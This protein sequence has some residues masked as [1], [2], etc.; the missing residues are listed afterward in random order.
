[1]AIAAVGA[2]VLSNII[3][4]M[5]YFGVWYFFPFVELTILFVGLGNLKKV[6]LSRTALSV[7]YPVFGKPLFIDQKDFSRLKFK[8]SLIHESES[9][10][11]YDEI[12]L[13]VDKN[14]IAKKVFDVDRT[15]PRLYRNSS[16]AGVEWEFDYNIRESFQRRMKNYEKRL[17][18]QAKNLAK[19][20]SR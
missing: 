15:A 2:F 14:K 18:I 9:D 4:E 8:I 12:K 16:R 1:M 5:G 19:R 7:T 10:V 20:K 3:G 6:E 11:D 13:F 17:E